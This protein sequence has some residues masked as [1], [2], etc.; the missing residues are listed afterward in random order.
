VSSDEFAVLLDHLQPAARTPTGSI[1]R[2]RTAGSTQA[3]AAEAGTLPAA[4]VT[5]SPAAVRAWARGNGFAIGDRGRL[6]LEVL[7]AYRRAHGVP[8]GR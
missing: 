3:V 8:A 5:V 6:P 1:P 2:P 7:D 4:H